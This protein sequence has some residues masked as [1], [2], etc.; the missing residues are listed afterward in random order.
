MVATLLYLSIDRL[1][2]R[3]SFHLARLI[4]YLPLNLTEVE[5]E[6]GSSFAK[7]G[8]LL[9]LPFH[10]LVLTL[11]ALQSQLRL[12]YFRVRVEAVGELRVIDRAK[13]H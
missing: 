10:V 8:V 5:G 4:S 7:N 6:V 12:H 2:H 1:L 11:K 9:V 13:V 3:C